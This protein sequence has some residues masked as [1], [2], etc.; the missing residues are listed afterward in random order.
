MSLLARHPQNVVAAAL[1]FG[2][3]CRTLAH[4][5]HLSLGA[6]GRFQAVCFAACVC[7]ACSGYLGLDWE[8]QSGERQPVL[9]SFPHPDPGYVPFSR[10]T[11][12]F[13][14][15]TVGPFGAYQT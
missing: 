14:F 1:S 12:A 11:A 6:R 3:Y 15:V 10:V 4:D 5:G 9:A 2:G 7:A 8:M 13:T